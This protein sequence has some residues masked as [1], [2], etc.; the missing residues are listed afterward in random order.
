M[1]SFV[2]SSQTSSFELVDLFLGNKTDRNNDDLA[3]MRCHR[4]SIK[5]EHFFFLTYDCI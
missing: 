2:V 3:H 4:I 1:V 5:T